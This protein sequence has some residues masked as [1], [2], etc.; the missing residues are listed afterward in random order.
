MKLV[1]F[2]FCQAYTEYCIYFKGFKR[3]WFDQQHPKSKQ[4]LQAIQKVFHSP[5]NKSICFSRLSWYKVQCIAFIV[6]NTP[7]FPYGLDLYIVYLID[8][9]GY[10]IFSYYLSSYA[11]HIFRNSDNKDINKNAYRSLMMYYAIS[12]FSVRHSLVKCSFSHT[13]N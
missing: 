11:N 6:V 1:F 10:Q 13:Q 8:Q 12:S 9:I 3:F 5:L 7:L 4:N 2:T